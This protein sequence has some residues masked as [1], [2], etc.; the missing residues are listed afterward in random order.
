MSA[1]LDPLQRLFDACYALIPRGM[2]ATAVAPIFVGHRGVCGHP[3][4]REN[5]VEAFEFAAIRGA[6]LEM[7]LH[8]TTDHQVIVHHD[9]SVLCEDGSEINVEEVPADQ[10]LSAAPFV[11]LLSDIL[12]SFLPRCPRLFLEVKVY[13]PEERLRTLLR[14]LGR[15]LDLRDARQA[16][17]L[18]SLDP[19]PLDVARELLNDIERVFVFGSI[20]SEEAV[21]YV[22]TWGDTGIAGW[23]FSFPTPIRE[24]LRERKLFEGVGYIDYSSTSVAL[25]NRG[26]RYQFTNRI[27]RLVESSTG[28]P[29][30]DC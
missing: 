13:Q 21:E 24:F 17:S 16:V 18:L 7:D 30:R 15:L 11:P 2:Q 12:D 4:I 22:K 25:A 9:P 19:R 6:A 10:L 29:A 1:I 14:E 23:Y 5:T 28:D 3:E 27:D 8:L 26:F 20:S